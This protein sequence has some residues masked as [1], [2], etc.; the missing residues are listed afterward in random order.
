MPLLTVLIIVAALCL[1]AALAGL[2]MNGRFFTRLDRVRRALPGLDCGVC[3]HAECIDFA[4][5]VARGTG[6]LTGCVPGGPATAHAIADILGSTVETGEPLVAAVNCQGGAA[7]VRERAR[8]E[9]IGDCVAA[10]LVGN[11][12]KACIEGCLGFG[13]CVRACPFGA[14]SISNDGIAVVDRHLCTSCGK[15]V[16]ACPRRLISLIPHVHKI[17]LACSNHDKGDRV[18]AT[19][20]VGCTGCEAC[21]TVTPSGGV[22]MENNLPRLDYFT[23]NENFVAAA[24]SCPQHCFVDLIKARPKA[25]IGMVCDGCGDCVAA[26][27]VQGAIVGEK[28]KR[29]TIKKDLCIGCGRCLNSCHVRAISLWGSLGYA[30]NYTDQ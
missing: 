8:Y 10:L 18:G 2:L 12:T 29:H 30:K 25:N 13:S 26:C 7:E 24:Y 23:P 19:C 1:A 28:G 17:Y 22:I 21:V 14:L 5:A 16:P 3:G 15:C 27:P 11:G 4:E 6:K 20:S 9:G